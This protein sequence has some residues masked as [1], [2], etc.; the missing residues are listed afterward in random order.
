MAVIYIAGI[1]SNAFAGRGIRPPQSPRTT[2]S[3]NG[4]AYNP[5]IHRYSGRPFSALSGTGL[6]AITVVHE[7]R[8]QDSPEEATAI[9]TAC[10][11]LLNDGSVTDEHGNERPLK[12]TDIMI[13]APYN[14]AVARIRLAVPAGVRVGTVDIFQ[15]REAPVVFYAMTCSTGEDVPRGL[16]FLFS[17]NRLNVA[18]SRAQCLAI[19]VYSPRLLDADCKTLEQMALVDGACRFVELA[20]PITTERPIASAPAGSHPDQRRSA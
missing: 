16:D 6:R 3:S 11:E 4:T 13:V 5:P 20:T 12:P 7:S 14:L 8:S 19:L 10:R 1:S 9:A 18:I 2:S 17:R 15:G